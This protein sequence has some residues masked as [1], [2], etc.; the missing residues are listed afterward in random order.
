MSSYG[1]QSSWEQ[2]EGQKGS[3]SIDNVH[4]L[5]VSEQ[6]VTVFSMALNNAIQNRYGIRVMKQ[7]PDALRSWLVNTFEDWLNNRGAQVRIQAQPRSDAALVRLINQASIA[8]AATNVWE[9]YQAYLAL[10]KDQDN[11]MEPID[12][13]IS[14]YKRGGNGE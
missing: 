13:P 2:N 4:A 12:L 14:T 11:L 8:P 7:D 10:V 5:I 6:N 9:N 1:F 3:L